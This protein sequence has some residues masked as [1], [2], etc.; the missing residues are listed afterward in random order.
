MNALPNFFIIG[1]R[2]CGTTALAQY[3]AEHPAILFYPTEPNF[4]CPDVELEPRDRASEAEYYGF[5]AAARPEHLALGEKSVTYMN[6][7]VAAGRIFRLQP[8]ARFIAIV[9]NPL[10]MAYSWYVWNRRRAFEPAPTFEQAWRLQVERKAG[11]AVP[12]NCP[13]PSFLQYGELCR[14]GAQLQRWYEQVPAEHLRLV[15]FEDFAAAP[16][17]IY[18]DTLRFLGLPSDG[19]EHF[20]IVNEGIYPRSVRLQ[21]L[22]LL[23]RRGSQ[24]LKRALGVERG[25]G[26]LSKVEA[27][28]ATPRLPLSPTFRAELA[29]FFAA[30]VGLVSRLAGRDLSYW[31]GAGA[32][33]PGGGSSKDRRGASPP[34]A[35]REA[36]RRKQ[37]PPSWHKT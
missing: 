35:E 2:R 14:V 6:S 27:A 1:A 4:F 33:A 30:D 21:R 17:D 26:A 16:A 28:L 9:R 34:G 31:L 5:F 8:G 32:G 7:T 15:L 10:E 37:A 29:E 24:G 3:L 36:P 22:L 12:H 18:E 11:R 23:A 20:P 13:T 25:F 19:R